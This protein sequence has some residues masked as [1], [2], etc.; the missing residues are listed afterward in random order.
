MGSKLSG[1]ELL[2]LRSF[3][4]HGYEVSLY[5]YDP[6]LNVP[7]GV[8]LR[9]ASSIMNE[10]SVFTVRGSYALFADVFRYRL[11]SSVDTVW[12]DTDCI[13][14]GPSFPTNEYFFAYDVYDNHHEVTN[15]VLRYPATSDLAELL[16]N[17]SSGMDVVGLYERE[18]NTPWGIT[19]PQ[20]LTRLVDELGIRGMTRAHWVTNPLSFRD[21]RLFFDSS[22]LPNF[23][24]LVER[25][26]IAHC[27]NVFVTLRDEG[28]GLDKNN[29]PEFSALWHLN[30]SYLRTK[31]SRLVINTGKSL[32]DCSF[33]EFCHEHDLRTFSSIGLKGASFD[34]WF[35]FERAINFID[36][37]G[38][39]HFRQFETNIYDNFGD[40]LF[41]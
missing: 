9:D 24:R 16:V 36:A 32:D 15:N 8:V 29:F 5:A 14:L 20:L 12:I 17:E 19:G 22:K 11:L 30:K 39:N 35:S 28:V 13:C 23:V 3:V 4:H 7:D 37:V 41:M 31:S 33:T 34:D 38:V 6:M 25:S 1:L 21:V 18:P 26:H 27:S 40:S 10:S 2:A